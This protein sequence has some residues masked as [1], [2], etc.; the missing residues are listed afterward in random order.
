LRFL[1]Q[2]GAPRHAEGFGSAP[3]MALIG[4]AHGCFLVAQAQ[5]FRRERILSTW[6]GPAA[7]GAA[8]LPLKG[9]SRGSGQAGFAL[10]H[11]PLPS[12]PDIAVILRWSS[13]YLE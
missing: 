13:N 8:A 7:A 12:G 9:A 5:M 1:E 6:P 2:G 10:V 3:G 11:S 4:R